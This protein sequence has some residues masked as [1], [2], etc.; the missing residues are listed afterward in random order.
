MGNDMELPLDCSLATRAHAAIMAV[1]EK[2]KATKTGGCKAFYS[3]EEW[4]ARGEQYAQE[5]VLV[6]VYD[7]GAH[8]PFFTLDECQYDLCEE[9][10]AALKPLGLY[11]EESTCW[12]GGVYRI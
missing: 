6:V 8:R 9:M 4:R 5:S 3:P 7:G 12:Y 10:Q 2:H 11:F 1:L